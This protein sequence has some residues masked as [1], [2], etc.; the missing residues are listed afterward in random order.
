MLFLIER[1]LKLTSYL[2]YDLFVKSTFRENEPSGNNTGC[3]FQCRIK[4]ERAKIMN[5]NT[6]LSNNFSMDSSHEAI[7]MMIQKH[8]DQNAV[9]RI[10][11]N[12]QA[13]SEKSHSNVI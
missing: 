12:V 8:R 5:F 4:R 9:S 10:C 11:Y 2:K 6:R 1:S 13:E 3:G 7:L